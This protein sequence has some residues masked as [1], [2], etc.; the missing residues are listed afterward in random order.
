MQQ[1]ITILMLL[2]Y[3][4]R[5]LYFAYLIDAQDGNKKVLHDLRLGE[6]YSLS[7]PVVTQE[8][9]TVNS[10]V[11][12]IYP[13]H[14]YYDDIVVGNIEIIEVFNDNKLMLI[15]RMLTITE[16]VYGV[17]SATCEGELS[18][19]NDVIYDNKLDFKMELSSLL[20]SIINKVNIR[21]KLSKNLN[22]SG[23]IVGIVKITGIFENTYTTYPT[24]W[25]L[26][27]D[28]INKFGGYLRTRYVEN[29]NGE[30][31][32]YIDYMPAFDDVC[33]QIVEIGKNIKTLSITSSAENLASYILPT[34]KV[35]Q[36]INDVETDVTIDLTTL[37][38]CSYVMSGAQP[39]KNSS[40]D[41]GDYYH[42]NG[43]KY[44]ASRS[45]E[46]TAG[47]IYMTYFDENATNADELAINAIKYLIKNNSSSVN[48]TV[49][50]IDLSLKDINI[51]EIEIAKNIPIYLP[52][53]NINTTVLCTKKETHL[54]KP[55]ADTI[56]L[57]NTTKFITK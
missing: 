44:I 34:C 56:S 42:T 28:V 8:L 24:C 36:T 6:C 18:Y 27:T 52:K 2:R 49:T 25:Q 32:T 14:R 47:C 43:S 23:F 40:V 9:N 38:A 19:F 46:N 51:P 12:N 45:L 39:I 3:E 41:V 31:I 16:D 29:D 21:K 5:L 30:I 15:C 55:D 10:F 17:K 54:T 53:K 1:L 33:G 37:E 48:F 4:V 26:I 20:S 35:K 11:F 50:I 22:F 57:G 7:E 13:T